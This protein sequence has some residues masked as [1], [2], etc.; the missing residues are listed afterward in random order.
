MWSCRPAVARSRIVLRSTVT[1]RFTPLQLSSFAVS[2]GH[3]LSGRVQHTYFAGHPVAHPTRPSHQYTTSAVES[4]S[5]RTRF[6]EARMAA[7]AIT[8]TEFRTW[9]KAN[10][11]VDLR[12]VSHE[13]A[14]LVLKLF[15]LPN[16]EAGFRFI[17]NAGEFPRCDVRFDWL[18]EG[19][20]GKWFD[21][22]NSC[23][24]GC[25]IWPLYYS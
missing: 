3:V 16:Q 15:F 12:E 6:E 1:A 7:C 23:N 5:W 11:N 10:V 24:N 18:R 4:T 9:G 13:F 19:E 8:L 22:Q 21:L 25:S 14:F 2:A 20:G 17:F